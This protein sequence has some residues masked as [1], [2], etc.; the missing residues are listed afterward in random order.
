MPSGVSKSNCCLKTLIG[1]IHLLCSPPPMNRTLVYQRHFVI[2]VE[3]ECW[4]ELSLWWEMYWIPSDLSHRWADPLSTQCTFE[5]L[6]LEVILDSSIGSHLFRNEYIRSWFRSLRT[7]TGCRWS[8]I[9]RTILVSWPYYT[10]ALLFNTGAAFMNP[11]L[12]M[13]RYNSF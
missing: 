2:T 8:C 12:F 11:P 5:T 3:H 13:N 4:R 6:S 7:P 1:I 10:Q 9:V